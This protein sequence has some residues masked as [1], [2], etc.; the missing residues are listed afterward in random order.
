MFDG[1]MFDGQRAIIGYQSSL[2]LGHFV[3]N[4]VLFLEQTFLRSLLKCFE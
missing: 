1:Q 2:P 3:A 4:V